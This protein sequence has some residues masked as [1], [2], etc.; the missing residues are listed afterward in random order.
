MLDINIDEP[1][2]I[3]DIDSYKHVFFGGSQTKMMEAYGKKQPQFSAWKRQNL[4]FIVLG[5]TH[6][7]VA[8]KNIINFND[9]AQDQK[10]FK[11]C[12]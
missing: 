12:E 8:K 11:T 4:V 2:Q 10:E 1:I 7:R 3:F 9:L 6:I 5:D